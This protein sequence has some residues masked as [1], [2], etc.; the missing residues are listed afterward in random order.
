[1]GF[2][3]RMVRAGVGGL[4]V[5]L[6]APLMI[7]GGTL[8]LVGEHRAADGTFAAPVEHLRS[9]GRAIVVTDVDAVLRSGAPFARGGETT[10]SISGRGPGGPLFFGLAPYADV[11]RYLAGVAQ[12]RVTRVRLAVG[13][14][15]VDATA[16]SGELAPTGPPAAQRFWLG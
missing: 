11:E 2:A 1:M 10:L 6:A 8:H 15:P 14:L 9:S 13:P 4:M 12:T 7:A 3:V 5:L 16:L